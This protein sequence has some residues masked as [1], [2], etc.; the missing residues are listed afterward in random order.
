MGPEVYARFLQTASEV[1]EE[2]RKAIEE[3]GP[4]DFPKRKDDGVA[5]F[6]ARVVVGQQLSTKAARSIWRRVEGSAESSGMGIPGFFEKSNEGVLRAC[7]VSKNKVRTLLGIRKAEAIGLLDRGKVHGMDHRSRSDHLMAMWG[8]GQ[9]TCDMVSI[10]YCRDHDVW[11]GGDVTVEK[12]F[13]RFTGRRNPSH[14]VKLFAPY[15]S[16]LALYMWRIVNAT[17]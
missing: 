1:S 11:P 4:I 13:V 16:F 6:L 7:G 15:R 5:S 2:L 8:V 10:F 3:I 17:P 14:A 12:T 9:W